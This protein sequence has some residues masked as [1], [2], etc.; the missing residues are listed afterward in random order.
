MAADS[1]GGRKK[2]G[3]IARQLRIASEVRQEPRT[4]VTLIRSWLARLW[5]ARGG[6]LYGLGVV[7]SFLV[8]EARTISGDFAAS[9]GIA[10]FLAGE[11]V[12]FVFRLG[13]M[14]F[15]NG[16]LALL[17]PVYVLERF[18]FWGLALLVAAYLVFEHALRPV[19]E[20]RLPELAEARAERAERK[21][22]KRA[23][24]EDKARRRAEKRS[25]RRR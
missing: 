20:S 25:S 9:A 22:E 16:F 10:D 6:G 3:R 4:A 23:R 17:W 2:E 12:E 15:L 11:I 21:R 1:G 24:K 5:A 13:F 14:S 8:L 19:V 18:E 7:V